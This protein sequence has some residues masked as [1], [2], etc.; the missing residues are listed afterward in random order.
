MCW[1]TELKVIRNKLGCKEKTVLVE[2]DESIT[3]IGLNRPEYR[4]S[5]NLCTLR[6]LNQAFRDFEEDNN[7]SVGVLYGVG[8]SFCAGYD[9][10]SLQEH[11]NEKKHCTLRQK[12]ENFVGSTRCHL[13][14]PMICGING[15][16]VAQGLELALMCDLRVMEDTAILGFFGRSMNFPLFNGSAM[17]LS[18]LIGHSR[19]LDL[20][21]TGRRV[22]AQEALEI[23]LIHRVV[24]T[25]SALGQAVHLAF[26]IAKYSQSSLL[27]DR[28]ELYSN[29]YKRRLTRN[30]NLPINVKNDMKE[31]LRRFVKRMYYAAILIEKFLFFNIK[32]ILFVYLSSFLADGIDFKAASWGIK[33]Q[34]I[35]SWEL[36]EI[37]LENAHISKKSKNS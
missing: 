37:A 24:A 6:Q 9:V 30:C 35:S 19:A 11:E 13:T 4:N 32:I 25:G 17:R 18:I 12:L 5:I 2:K 1:L 28:N 34:L 15:Y 33:D 23:G 20:L 26:S 7:S 14:K 31:C 16:C 29:S 8:G 3:L 27:Y 36:E 22:C 21:L 10:E